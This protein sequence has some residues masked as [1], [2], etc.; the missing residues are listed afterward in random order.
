MRRKR[1]GCGCGSCTASRRLCSAR[2]CLLTSCTDA[3][4]LGGK[5]ILIA[6]DFE[7]N[8][9]VLSETLRFFNKDIII[10]QAENG[11]KALERLNEERVDMVVMD[12]DMP[13]MNGFEA[14]SAIRKDKKLKKIKVVAS[15][16]SLITDGD[17]EFLTFGF[18]GYLPKPFDVEQFYI[19]LE[20]ML[21]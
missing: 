16:A 14:L 6:D 3:L 15:T 21:K 9:F 1:C 2:R 17:T 8:R 12:L 13:E 18:D 7:D 5:S 10:H 4:F 19:L 11:L 20:K